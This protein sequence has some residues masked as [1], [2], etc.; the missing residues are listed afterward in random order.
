MKDVQNSKPRSKMT[1]YLVVLTS[2][3]IVLFVAADKQEIFLALASFVIYATLDILVSK[4]KERQVL[5]TTWQR[6]V[7]DLLCVFLSTAFFLALL[8]SVQSIP[9]GLK[10]IVCVG[11][12]VV[13]ILAANFVEARKG[14]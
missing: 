6:H 1:F 5:K 2:F 12:S 3:A 14:E 4:L 13:V 8:P 10:L 11:F 7:A 9:L